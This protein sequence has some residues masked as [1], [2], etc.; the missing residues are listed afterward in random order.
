LLRQ[1]ILALLLAA[2]AVSSQATLSAG[3]I[4]FTSFDADEDGLSFVA[5]RDISAN[6]SVYFSDNEWSGDAF[7]SGESYNVWNSGSGIAAGTVVRFSAYDK[8]SLAASVGSLS[9]VTVTGSSNWGIANSNET[10]YAYLGSATLPTTFLAA[11]TNGSFS[12]DGPLTGTGLVEGSSAIRLNAVATSATPDY[13][14]YTGPRNGLASFNAYKSQV[15]TVANWIVDTTNGNYATTVPN[16]TAFSVTAVP[17][18]D[19]Y[20]ML[21]AGLGLMGFIARRRSH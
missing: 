3:D 13:A 2:S 16:L 8:T 17:E 12:A 14:A 4:A 7:N 5:F 1:S 9:R 10:V 19:R 20:A 11:I 21:L 15:G 6:T 18:P